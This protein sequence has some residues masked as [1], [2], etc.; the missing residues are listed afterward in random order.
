MEAPKSR[1]ATLSA[2]TTRKIEY[3]YRELQTAMSYLTGLKGD[4]DTDY[5]IKV[6]ET[7]LFKTK[8][9]F[10]RYISPVKYEIPKVFTSLV[11]PISN[12]EDNVNMLMA[13]RS[14]R[15]VEDLI[16]CAAVKNQ[17]YSY[18]NK[19]LFNVLEII[20]CYKQVLSNPR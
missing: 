1:P 14:T 7:L 17:F 6:L 10:N 12:F 20:E 19:A 13:L 18:F 16:D 8:G 11:P 4:L 15:R 5:K 3:R 2:N 9:T